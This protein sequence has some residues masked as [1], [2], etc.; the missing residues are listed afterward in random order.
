MKIFGYIDDFLVIAYHW[1]DFIQN[2][3]IHK[4]VFIAIGLIIIKL[5]SDWVKK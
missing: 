3:T 1:L 4:L 2:E 5:L